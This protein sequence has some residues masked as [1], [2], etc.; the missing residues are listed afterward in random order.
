MSVQLD[1]VITDDWELRGDG[2][3]DMQVIQFDT[4]RRFADVFAQQGLHVSFNVEVLQQLRHLQFAPEHPRLSELAAQWERTLLDL[5]RQG[6]DIQLHAH[7]QWTDVD[8]VDE[9]W[10]LNGDWSILRY[11]RA[12][13]VAILQEAKHYLEQLMRRADPDY[14]CVAFRSGGWCLAPSPHMLEV[15]RELGIEIDISI[16][17]GLHYNQL[18]ELDYREIEEPVEPFHPRLD[19]ARRLGGV[20]SLPVCCPVVHYRQSGMGRIGE[21]LARR[22]GTGIGLYQPGDFVAPSSVPIPG[23]AANRYG[24][25]SYD[26]GGPVRSSLL[27]KVRRVLQ[28][29]TLTADISGMNLFQVRAMIARLQREARRRGLTRLPVIL[30]HHTKDMG[31]IQVAEG[32]ARLIADSAGMD[33]LTLAQ[34]AANIAAGCYRVRYACD[35]Y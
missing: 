12:Q 17:Q 14:R 23:A 8:Y 6:H 30:A 25:W 5:Y 31:D 34:L 13:V 24:G 15:L 32:L 7:T 1:F 33:T 35:G 27:A 20:D 2:S 9:R 11:P 4:G 3:G 28:A 26:G 19:D 29:R 10:V 18:V 21:I 16:T 22:L